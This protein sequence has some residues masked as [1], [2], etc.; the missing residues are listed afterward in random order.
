MF[1]K[2]H[3]MISQADLCITWS[4]RINRRKFA[5]FGRLR[6]LMSGELHDLDY[7]VAGYDD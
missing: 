1:I 6:K 4:R 2:D 3:Y 7:Q 5:L